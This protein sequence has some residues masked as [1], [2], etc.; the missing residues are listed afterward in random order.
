MPGSGEW[1]LRGVSV[2]VA[3]GERL[4]VTGPTGAGKTLLLRALA[5]LD[6]LDEGEVR[7]RGRAVAPAEVP[8][9]RARA[10]YLHQRPG[11]FEGT[12]ADNLRAPFELAVHRGRAYDEPSVIALLEGLGRGRSFLTKASSDL[13]GGEAQLTAFLRAIQVGP[14][15]LLLDEPTAALDREAAGMIEVLVDRWLVERRD[16]RAL[17]WVTHD[18]AQAERVATRA[19]RLEAGRRAA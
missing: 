18:L 4:A 3:A 16:E 12:V 2:A 5:L 6:P 13:S 1:L 9:F 11:I 14:E 8:A 17:V 7:W 19:L 15:V 10:V